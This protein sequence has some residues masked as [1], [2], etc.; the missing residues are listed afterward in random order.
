MLV[1]VPLWMGLTIDDQEPELAPVHPGWR[2]RTGLA[3]RGGSAPG[4]RTAGVCAR[5]QF[6]QRGQDP[7]PA[8]LGFL[9]SI[10]E[11]GLVGLQ[12]DG[13]AARAGPDLPGQVH[14]RLTWSGLQ[15]VGQPA[16]RLDVQS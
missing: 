12:P 2:A 8:V 6:L 14:R 4:W 3:R 16:G 9:A 5:E 7:Q 15:E 10:W 11:V 13:G 1:R